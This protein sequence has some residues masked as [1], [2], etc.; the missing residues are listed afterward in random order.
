MRILYRPKIGLDSLLLLSTPP[1][2]SSSHL[3]TLY[4]LRVPPHTIFIHLLEPSLLFERDSVSVCLREA[5][6]RANFTS[7]S[8][9]HSL[10]RPETFSRDIRKVL[11]LSYTLKGDKSHFFLFLHIV[12][13]IFSALLNFR[14]L[15]CLKL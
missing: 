14:K 4:F 3:Q 11:S 1:P 7:A 12:W 13:R 5:G 15:I 10:T 8:S 9:V 6:R 2:P